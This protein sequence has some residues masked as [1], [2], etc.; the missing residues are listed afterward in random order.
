M[1]KKSKMKVAI[2]FYGLVGSTT[3]KYG[4]GKKL[5][6]TIAYQYY[7]KNVFK[8]LT[9]FDV[10]IHSQ[11]IEKKNK[12]KKLYKPA[13]YKIEHQK[14]F[15]LNTITHPQVLLALILFPYNIF[16]NLIFKKNNF[17]KSFK[18]KF[19]RCYNAYSRWYS[20]KEAV[21][22]KKKYEI[23]NNFKYDL[24]FLTRLD[25]AFITSFYFKKIDGKFLT[26]PNH[27]DV[28][29]PRNNYMQKVQ[30]NNKTYEK[31]I[32]DFWFIS[33]SDNIDKFASLVNRFKK[34]NI[35]NHISSLQ[36]SK[37]LKLKLRFYKYR[38]L[39]HEAIRRLKFSKE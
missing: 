16:K 20:L 13:A 34:Y 23:E 2:C 3:K 14:N 22:L 10:F 17:T 36:H 31:G 11:S 1:T 5:D 19:V 33:A 12:L 29:T 37:Y 32:S 30:L 6:P 9:D 39:D 24:V 15:F 35:S 8:N 21:D 7:Q 18:S 25:L 26:V 38:G 28:P 27:N 4:L